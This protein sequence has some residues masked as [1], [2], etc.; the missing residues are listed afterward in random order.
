[1]TKNDAVV[2]V[3][4]DHHGAEAAIRKLAGGGWT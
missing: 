3:F 1:M 2:A 4:T